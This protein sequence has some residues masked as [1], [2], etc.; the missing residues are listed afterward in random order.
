MSFNWLLH[1]HLGEED[2]LKL[3]IMK[4]IFGIEH[5]PAGVLLRLSFSRRTYEPGEQIA[6]EFD[7]P[8]EDGQEV[9]SPPIYPAVMFNLIRNFYE[10]QP[11]DIE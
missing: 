10:V 4:Q 5:V 8:W 7:P 6:I 9:V 3:E 1:Q 11:A 2:Q